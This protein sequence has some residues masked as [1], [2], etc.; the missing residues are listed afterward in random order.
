MYDLVKI[1]AIFITTVLLGYYP[2]FNAFIYSEDVKEVHNI[3]GKYWETNE[4]KKVN[5][6]SPS[7][8]KIGVSELIPKLQL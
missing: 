7:V 6:P 1:Q 5:Y 8:I 3:H 2:E 4:V